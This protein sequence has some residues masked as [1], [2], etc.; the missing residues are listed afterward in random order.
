MAL[1]ST[2][3]GL[4]FSQVGTTATHACTAA[5]STLYPI[6]HGEGCAFTLDTWLRINSKGRPALDQVAR[7]IGFA[8]AEAMADRILAMKR[9]LGC[10]TRL[11]ELGGTQTDIPILAKLSAESRNM[12]VNVVRATQAELE[13]IYQALL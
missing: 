5:L 9:D 4:A 13:A 2:L 11:T 10:R 8:D 12:A 7:Q 3:A 1:A 6:S